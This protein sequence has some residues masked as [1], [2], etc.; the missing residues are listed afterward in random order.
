MTSTEWHQQ[1]DINRVTLTEWHQQSEFKRVL[2][3]V[4]TGNLTEAKADKLTNTW[5]LTHKHPHYHQ[6]T[7]KI[8]QVLRLPVDLATQECLSCFCHIFGPSMDCTYDFIPFT[9]RRWTST[10]NLRMCHIA[11]TTVLSKTEYRI[12]YGNVTCNCTSTLHTAYWTLYRAHHTRILNSAH[13]SH[14]K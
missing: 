7:V 6:P 12:L 9:C 11:L 4:G 13:L 2:A 14:P 3:M 8:W 5:K 1:S 10:W